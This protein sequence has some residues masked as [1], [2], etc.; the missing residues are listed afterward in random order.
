MRVAALISGGKDSLLAFHLASKHHEVGCFVTVIPSNPDSFMY[1]TPN[2]N[3]VDA[4]ASSIGK[5]ILKVPS[6]GLEES[7]VEDLLKAVE[8]LKVDGLVVGGIAS[9][10]QKKR[11]ERICESIGIELIAPLWGWKDEEVISTASELFEAVIVKVSA[12]GLDE[13]WLG[14]RIDGELIENLKKVKER[15]GINLAGEGGEFETLVL[16]APF[17]R[18]RIRIK[19]SHVVSDPLSATLIVD[20]FYLEEKPKQIGQ[21]F[22]R[23]DAQ[24]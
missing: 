10:Y 6:S 2:L 22:S 3:L 20:E 13:S 7:E 4:I 21:A 17:F 24:V 23:S 19:G 1:H 8:L 11:F 16:D 15:Y 9:S 14:K 12:M 18:R 5:P